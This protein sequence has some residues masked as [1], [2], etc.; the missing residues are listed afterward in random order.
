MF[1][2]LWWQGYNGRVGLLSWPTL[3]GFLTFDESEVRAWNSAEAFKLVLLNDLKKYWG[4]IRIIGHSMGGI[5]SGETVNKLP[6]SGIVK[7]YI[8]SQTA[9]SA[10]YYDNSVTQKSLAAKMK[11]DFT[12]NI[13]GYFPSGNDTSSDV[14]YLASSVIKA[15]HFNYFNLYD[16]ALSRGEL[17]VAAWEGNNLLRP[18]T[19]Y[20]HIPFSALYMRGTS[21]LNLPDDKYEIFGNIILSKSK[22]LGATTQP[23]D[24]FIQKDIRDLFGFDR[25]SYSHSRQFRSHIINECGYWKEVITDFELSI[26]ITNKE[27]S[28]TEN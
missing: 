25:R 11:M 16:F 15:K 20:S 18:H 14:P 19:P 9:L 3:E 22:A 4:N 6:G 12:P 8:A 28:C 5:V 7:A 26:S 27:Q 13:F 21:L 23:V 1:K 2:R 24:G 17:G 10:H